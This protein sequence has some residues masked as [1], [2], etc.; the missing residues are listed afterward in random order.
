MDTSSLTT[1][2]TA[3]WSAMRANFRTILLCLAAVA[4]LSV[5]MQVVVGERVGTAAATQVR[6]LVGEARYQELATELQLQ[7]GATTAR[8]QEFSRRVGDEV[9]LK[10]E[11]LDREERQEFLMTALQEGL[12]ELLPVLLIFGPLFLLLIAWSRAFFLRLAVAPA[13][14]P[15]AIGRATQTFLPLTAVYIVMLVAG[16][17]WLPPLCFLL[18]SYSPYFAFLFVLS[19]LGPVILL[20]RLALAPAYYVKE[21]GIVKSLENSFHRTKGVWWKVVGSLAA[22]SLL[23]FLVLWFALTVIDI[24]AA[25]IAVSGV[26]LVLYWL[27]QVFSFAAAGYRTIF[28]LRLAEAV[29]KNPRRPMRVKSS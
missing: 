11:A 21:G 7:E 9:R 19:F 10:F 24:V 13:P 25:V 14:F 6:R 5:L 3:S 15:V 8:W 23:S 26:L 27:R 29:Q 4:V 1:L 16:L 12:R 22:A 18:I 2:L 17:A 20:P 28:L